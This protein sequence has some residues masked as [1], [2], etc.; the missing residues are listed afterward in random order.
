MHSSCD[1]RASNEKTL[2]YFHSKGFL[3]FLV[4]AAGL[5]PATP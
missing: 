1:I 3:K 2:R 4:L 5:E